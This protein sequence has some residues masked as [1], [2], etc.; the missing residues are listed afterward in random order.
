MAV[1]SEARTTVRNAG[2]ILVQRGL[3]AASGFAFALVVP[4]LMGPDIY[5]RY[6]LI[7]SLSIWFLLFSNLSLTDVIGRYVPEF[8][9]RGDRKGLH[10]FWADLLTVRL[11][12]ATL[13]ASVYLGVTVL[14]LR[15]LELLVLVIMAGMVFVRGIAE[16]LFAVFVGYNQASRWQMGETLRQWLSLGI[17]LPSFYLGGLRGAVLGLLLTEFVVLALG[18]CWAR[19]HLAWPGLHLD[20]R[21][22]M[23]YLQFGL[24]FFASDVLNTALGA[25]GETMLRAVTM[26]YVQVGYFGL[27][28]RVYITMALAIPYVTLTFTPLLTTLRAQGRIETLTWWLERL[29]K[30]LAFGGVLAAFGTLLLAEDL[31][32]MVLGAEYRPVAGT[33]VLLTLT[34]L[35]SAIGFIA[36]LVAMIYVRPRAA[37][38]ASAIRLV[39]FWILGAP[40]V[41][42]FG[43]L[44]SS[45]AMLAVS[46][47]HAGYFTWRMR[48]VLRYSLRECLVTIGLGILFLPLLLLRSSWTMNVA[49]FGVFVLGYSSVLLLLRV[50]TRNEVSELWQAIVSRSETFKHV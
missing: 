19:L 45:T 6:S 34:L 1:I 32:P 46:A 33:L 31:V 21:R 9:L 5:G 44:G 20:V 8:I 22:S 42:R 40:L 10:E 16:L 26:D 30:Y 50:V 25:S 27:A 29:L 37:L 14:W 11:A 17:L 48:R 23:P 41:A 38:A 15:D 35:P 3:H 12:T 47:L 36:R 28:W 24:I 13:A 4:R 39:A 18:I 49:L 43:S 7:A 2:G